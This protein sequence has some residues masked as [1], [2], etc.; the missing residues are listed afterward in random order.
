MSSYPRK[1]SDCVNY[2][3]LDPFK[4]KA[5][6]IFEST[7]QHPERLRIRVYPAGETAA[8]LDFLGYDFMLAFNIE[9]L[10]TKNMISDSIYKE[11]R[12]KVEIAE[13]VKAPKAYRNTGKCTMLMSIIDLVAVGADPIAYCD[14]IASGNSKWFS[15]EERN[16]NLLSG[17][18]D[19]ADEVGCAI[20]QGETPTLRGI[21][22]PETL[23]L[24]GSSIG[25]IRPKERFTYGQKL[26]EGDVIYGLPTISPCAN[27]ISKIR[28]IAEKLPKGY[29]TELSS[30]RTLGEAVLEPTPNYVRKIINMFEDGVDIHYIA[31]ITGHGW[32]K[33]GRARFPFTHI[34]ENVPD[35]PEVFQFLI[36]QGKNHGFDVSDKENYYVWNMGVFVTIHAPEKDGE[37]IDKIIAPD[38]VYRLGRIEK[39]DRKVIINS[40]NIEF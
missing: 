15:D 34:V 7:L 24:A 3:D 1:Y 32:K 27:G 9:G 22:S 33:I 23:D 30:G 6:E 20:P 36:E 39:G 11:L 35:P 14:L 31:P 29:F 5:M 13:R 21:I 16:Q 37:K 2:D 4:R 25:L 18:K 28:E 40:K 26:E 10:G 12:E 38:H 8:V 17:Y 19:V